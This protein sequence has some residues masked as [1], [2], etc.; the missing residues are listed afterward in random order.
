[1]KFEQ[2]FY[3]R[4]KGK[5]Q[6]IVAAS[7]SE[8]SFLNSSQQ[9][10]AQFSRETT[11]LTAPTARFVVYSSD[12]RRFVGVGVSPRKYSDGSDGSWLTHIFVP[13]DPSG[14]PSDYFLPYTFARTVEEG[15]TYETAEF[16]PKDEKNEF[17]QIL[18]NCFS[19]DT[20]KLAAFLHQTL[21]TVSGN[22]YPLELLLPQDSCSEEEGAEFARQA[23]R[24]LT[25]LIPLPEEERKKF[26]EKISYSVF[27]ET[28]IKNVALAYVKN[29]VDASDPCFSFDKPETQA[30]PAV[31][32]KLAE[33]AMDSESA[34]E[35][36]VRELFSEELDSKAGFSDEKLQMQYLAWMTKKGV[37]DH[38][39]TS[40][41][42]PIRSDTLLANA[43][44]RSLLF[45][46]ILKIKE[47][48]DVKI[49]ITQL[50]EK[51]QSV[52]RQDQLYDKAIEACAHLIAIDANA[53]HRRWYLNQLEMERK[54]EVVKKLWKHD[55][56]MIKKDVTTD[57]RVDTYVERVRL[58]QSL[59]QEP[60]FV[61]AV[62]GVIFDH[63]L[64][65]GKT[66]S[67]RANIS[68]VF[69][70]DGQ[71]ENT[72]WR[73]QLKTQF[74]ERLDGK[75]DEIKVFVEQETENSEQKYATLFFDCL[76]KRYQ[77]ERNINE[78]YEAMY[79]LVD[80]FI[81]KHHTTEGMDSL[82]ERF[83]QFE[84]KRREQAAR[85]EIQESKTISD[86][87]AKA[88]TII[89]GT[90][91]EYCAAVAEVCEEEIAKRLKN[92]TLNEK[93]IKPMLGFAAKVKATLKDIF[94]VFF[95]QVT[96]SY[97]RYL[98]DEFGDMSLAKLASDYDTYCGKIWP[99]DEKIKRELEDDSVKEFQTDINYIWTK[100]V[101]K[102]LEKL[103]K[104]ADSADDKKLTEEVSAD[105]VSDEKLTKEVFL[106]LLKH[107][108]IFNDH[109]DVKNSL[110]NALFAT[111]YP[112]EKE[113]LAECWKE[114]CDTFKSNLWEK[115]ETIADFDFYK[116]MYACLSKKKQISDIKKDGNNGNR[117][118]ILNAE[119]FA[120][121]RKIYC[122]KGWDIEDIQ[123]PY[124]SYRRYPDDHKG[125]D[126]FADMIE[127]LAEK[128]ERDKKYLDEFLLLAAI[129]EPEYNWIQWYEEKETD[130]REGLI[131]QLNARERKWGQF[132]ND[133][134]NVCEKLCCIH[135]LRT[136]TLKEDNWDHCGK[137]LCEA[138]K[139]LGKDIEKEI[140]Y[141]DFVKMAES[142]PDQY[143]QQINGI[144]ETRKE[145]KTI[146]DQ[147]EKLL[148]EL[149]ELIDKLR[150]NNATEKK[151]TQAI[152][153]YNEKRRVYYELIDKKMDVTDSSISKAETQKKCQEFETKL[154]GLVNELKL[155]KEYE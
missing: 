10:G 101:Y 62:C 123:K 113:T 128:A 143:S 133:I 94:S 80:A 122:D 111:F 78:N 150:T 47:P 89:D 38:F 5:G 140:L 116:A 16:C 98:K 41:E 112:S 127:K 153:E 117:N 20:K 129:R 9:L 11:D 32:L 74:D 114:Y 83:H 109:T 131:S 144:K 4:E 96:D 56:D 154:Q 110:Q 61:K 99:E 54:A 18:K 103:V 42:L 52:G 34:Y 57:I 36:F 68:N 24:L 97:N 151:L 29:V 51:T 76:F 124:Q 82:T 73:E 135:E 126:K 92:E 147:V 134:K 8:R 155:A 71:T 86:A 37:L 70:T 130:V 106:E 59:V 40:E 115:K 149:G 3:T 87:G 93:S 17:S 46:W 45:A 108:T 28:N 136:T 148:E 121:W 107:G 15:K 48:S 95:S 39:P 53:A 35:A 50:F 22:R 30:T 118:A 145:K 139:L 2:S 77:Q 58:Y 142:T 102:K 7:R 67:E 120:L 44:Y 100:A 75:A 1:M 141:A 31:Y 26:C 13:Q 79:L 33:K 21:R 81:D 64:Y 146:M 66:A 27:S 65:F 90:P 125:K 85:K 119:C 63:A 12:F 152:E 14:D 69:E 138:K 55:P 43:E 23:T 84:T 88:K 105:G 91:R 104:Q 19:D 60:E 49:R 132:G 25:K 6:S 72:A 137:I